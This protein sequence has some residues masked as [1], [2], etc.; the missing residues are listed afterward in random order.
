MP[1]HVHLLVTPLPID[2]DTWHSLPKLLH[3]V[4]SYS[5]NAI[6]KQRQSS[7]TLWQDEYFD[8]IVRDDAEFVEK[9][10]YIANNPR[11]RWPELEHYGWVWIEGDSK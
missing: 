9:L 1:D 3:S 6:N 4:K 7:G 8:R 5:A 11:K 2:G 10:G